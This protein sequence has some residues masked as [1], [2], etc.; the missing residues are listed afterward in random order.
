MF[1][2]LYNYGVMPDRPKP[3]ESRQAIARIISAAAPDIL[4]VCELG[5]ETHGQALCDALRERDLDFPYRTIVTG[6]DA[7]RHL[8]VFSRHS[9]LA[10]LNDVYSTYEI[11]GETMLVRRGFAH[12]VFRLDNGYTFHLVVAHL[13][14]KVFHAMG[15]SDMRRYEARLV[16]YLVT[17]ILDANPEANVLV[18]GDMNDSHNA[19][20]IKSIVNNRFNAE[21]RLYDLRPVDSLLASWTHLW[22]D[23]DIYSRYDYAFGSYG[24]LPEIRFD[25][26][27]ILDPPDWFKASDHRAVYVRIHGA[28]LP[29]EP[30]LLDNFDMSVRKPPIPPLPQ[31]GRII[32]TRKARRGGG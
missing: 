28:D 26:C 20:P 7:S 29:R 9:P 22:D 8:A 13:K 15:Q 27:A 16:R 12:V 32:G 21:K 31:E 2:N 23:A 1:Y 17:D 11:N 10:I 18:V 24:I 3:P 6:P 25:E 19:S 5:S 30:D 4:A 14:S